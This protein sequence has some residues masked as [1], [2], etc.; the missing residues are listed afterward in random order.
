MVIWF[1]LFQH[2]KHRYFISSNIFIHYIISINRKANKARRYK[3]IVGLELLH[4]SNVSLACLLPCQWT[5][6][7]HL[8]PRIEGNTSPGSPQSEPDEASHEYTCLVA[9]SALFCRLV[10]SAVFSFHSNPVKKLTITTLKKMAYILSQIKFQSSKSF[11]LTRPLLHAKS[12][13]MHTSPLQSHF[14]HRTLACCCLP[15]SLWWR[16][17]SID[18]SLFPCGQCKTNNIVA[19]YIMLGLSA[20]N[21]ALSGHILCRDFSSSGYQE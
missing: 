19:L 4:L 11:V 18:L 8:T 15:P 17:G 13:L 10:T 9:I 21:R 14:C 12:P 3:Y 1:H 7:P 2:M 20:R 6:L 5:S 16:Q